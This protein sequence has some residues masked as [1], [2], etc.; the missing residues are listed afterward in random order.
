MRKETIDYSAFEKRLLVLQKRNSKEQ[1]S[2]MVVAIDF[3]GTITKDNEFP[4]KIG[5]LRD[6]CKE[7]IDYIRE[8]H[9]VIIWTCRSGEYLAEAVKFLNDNGIGYDAINADIYPKT[10]RKIMA[11]IYI[12]DKNI[13]CKEVDWAKIKKYFESVR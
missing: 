9:K 2:G 1:K 5:V 8:N 13:F 10:D 12:D 11:D 3:D 7:A 6:G 4:E